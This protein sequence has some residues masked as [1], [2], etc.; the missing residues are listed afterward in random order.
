MRAVLQSGG[1][2]G[3][4]TTGHV[5][6]G[7]AKDYITSPPSTGGLMPA[8]ATAAAAATGGSATSG[9]VPSRDLSGGAGA[10]GM[11]GDHD[12]GAHHH[13]VPGAL[14]AAEERIPGMHSHQ[15]AATTA[16]G[17][18][19]ARETPGGVAADVYEPEAIR[20]ARGKGAIAAI[21]DALKEAVTINPPPGPH[22]ARA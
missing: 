20:E 21:T 22:N 19:T 17:P 18:A 1:M 3:S 5:G 10:G 4:G 8:T 14:R 13:G 9:H 6:R 2:G 16:A 7:H 15:H 12:D 11:H